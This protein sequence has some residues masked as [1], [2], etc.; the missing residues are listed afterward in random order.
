MDLYKTLSK[1]KVINKV[2]YYFMGLKYLYNLCEGDIENDKCLVMFNNYMKFNQDLKTQKP[3]ME[4]AISIVELIDKVIA[5]EFV[6]ERGLNIQDLKVFSKCEHLFKFCIA[7]RQANYNDLNEDSQRVIDV[8]L[9]NSINI[10]S[11]YLIQL[12]EDIKKLKN[13]SFIELCSFLNFKYKELRDS[14]DMMYQRIVDCINKFEA[15]KNWYN[16]QLDTDENTLQ[17]IKETLETGVIHWTRN[18]SVYQM[19]IA[20]PQSTLQN[21]KLNQHCGKAILMIDPDN[22]GENS[23]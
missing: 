1:V 9:I 21:D 2:V 7:N 23:E 14:K 10:V 4:D 3:T 12:E 5:K 19:H 22:G 18:E 15:I 17:C 20:L 11:Q 8:G 13:I 6:E 16:T